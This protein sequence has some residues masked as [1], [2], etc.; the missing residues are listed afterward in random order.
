MNPIAR[1]RFAPAMRPLRGDPFVH[2]FCTYWAEPEADMDPVIE[3][4]DV[5]KVYRTGTLAVAALRG[6]S[7]TI[8]PGEYV[9]IMG[10]SGSGNGEAPRVDTAWARRGVWATTTPA[11][12]C[13]TRAV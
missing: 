6:V 1:F 13:C 2:T 7:F 4:E 9:S 10:P 3:L 12:S 11:S 8:Y 5:T